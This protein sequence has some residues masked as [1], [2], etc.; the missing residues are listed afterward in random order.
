MKKIL[1]ASVGIMALAGCSIMPPEAYYDR[2][3]PE[4]LLDV[5]SEV[6]NLPVHSESSLDELTNWINKDQPSRAELYCSPASSQCQAAQDVLDLYGVPTLVMPSDDSM[7]S[8]VYERVLARDCENR[9]IDNSVNPYNLNHP[10]FGCSLSV[11]MVQ[12]VSDKHQFVRPNLMDNPD[13]RKAV[14]AYQ[15]YLEPPVVKQDDGG[16]KNSLIEEAKID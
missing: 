10:T 2:G 5:S 13:A 3:Q 4:S 1:L 8:L 15:S 16:V 11:N 6:V 12:M 7:V 14:Q 9:Y